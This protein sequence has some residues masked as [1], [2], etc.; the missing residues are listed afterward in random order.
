MADGVRKSF[1]KIFENEGKLSEEKAAEE[2]EKLL[3]KGNY[4]EDV[5]GAVHRK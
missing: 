3:D 2:F 1:V 5:F 4:H